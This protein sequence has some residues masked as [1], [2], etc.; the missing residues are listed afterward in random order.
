[1]PDVYN[2]DYRLAVNQLE[3]LGFSQAAGTL[4]IREEYH[5]DIS[6]N[7]VIS[8]TPAAETPLNEVERVELVVSRGP[9]PELSTVIDFVT[10]PLEEARKAAEE[11]LKLVVS[12]VTEEYS[13][14]VKAGCITWQSIDPNTRVEEGTAIRFRVSLG[15][16]PSTEP[17]PPPTPSAQ[18]EPTPGGGT[19]L[20]TSSVRVDLPRDGRT[21]V[22][23]VVTVDGVEQYREVVD[24]QMQ[25]VTVPVQG[26]GIQTVTVYIDGVE[27]WSR[28]VSFS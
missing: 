19:E 1:M 10:M 22:E 18:P 24:T 2:R 3:K 23:V 9:E 11:T 27:N 17:S 14:D 4:T 15:P 7:Y 26:S 8:Q 28:A 25:L 21:Q 16:D 5:D 12:E 13:A 20:V 6:E